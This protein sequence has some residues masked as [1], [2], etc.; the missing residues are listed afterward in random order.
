MLTINNNYGIVTMVDSGE[1][2]LFFGMGLRV[3]PTRGQTY[4]DYKNE[5]PLN[6]IQKFEDWENKDS[7]RKLLVSAA[8]FVQSIFSLE[9]DNG[10]FNGYFKPDNETGIKR[11]PDGKVHIKK[12]KGSEDYWNE[13]SELLLNPE[14][15]KQLLSEAKNQS[16]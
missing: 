15:Y 6:Y 2:K 1:K 8:N 11:C 12:I 13:D 10:R 7:G 16:I 3:L 9:L 4:W 14:E 5:I